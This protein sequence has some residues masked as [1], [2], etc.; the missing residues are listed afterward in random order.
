MLAVL[1][2]WPSPCLEVFKAWKVESTALHLPGL[3]SPWHPSQILPRRPCG[4]APSDC[5]H[6]WSA[7]HPASHGCYCSGAFNGAG[8]CWKRWAV[9]GCMMGCT[10]QKHPNTLLDSTWSLLGSSGAL[11]Y[12]VLDSK[13]RSWYHIIASGFCDALSLRPCQC[14]RVL[15]CKAIFDQKKVIPWPVASVA[16]M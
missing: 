7:V 10:C 1:E 6:D 16:C 12:I 13:L 4:T 15:A 5:H 3:Q 2:N 14:C 11:C 8:T 9:M